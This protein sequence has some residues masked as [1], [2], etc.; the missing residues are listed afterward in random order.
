MG[1]RSNFDRI[2]KDKYN[3]I[4]K[5]AVPPLLKHLDSQYYVELCAGK[6]CLIDQLSRYGMICAYACDIEPDGLGIEQRDALTVTN[7]RYQIIT[8]PPWNRKVLHAMIEHFR[9]LGVDVWLLFDAGWAYSERAAPY[10]KYCHK[11]IA[12]PRLRWFKDTK[13]DA[14][15][16]C[17]WYLF[18]PEQGDTIFVN[19]R[20]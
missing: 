19:E 1:R 2:D 14:M 18:R 5:R 12:L 11:I 3:T 16:D 7:V 15:D 20:K 10:M 17:A 9:K 4:D 6:G 13:H 8:N